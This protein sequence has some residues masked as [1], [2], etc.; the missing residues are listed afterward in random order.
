MRH[1]GGGRF[2]EVFSNDFAFAVVV[3]VVAVV[4]VVFCL[5]TDAG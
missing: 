5:I 1:G 4:F 2:A 3:V